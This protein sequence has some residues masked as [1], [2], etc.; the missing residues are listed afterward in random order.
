MSKYGNAPL[1]RT[2]WLASQAALLKPAKS[3][4]S[5]AVGFRKAALDFDAGDGESPRSDH[6]GQLVR[7]RSESRDRE[8]ILRQI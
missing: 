3:L 1:R 7:V 2:L 6:V 8:S 5:H 4:S